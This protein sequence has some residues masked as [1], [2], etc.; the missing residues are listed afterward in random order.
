[1][2]QILGTK[3]TSKCMYCD[4]EAYGYGCPYSPHHRHVHVDDSKRCIYCGSTNFGIGCPYN[5]FAKIHV[6]GLEFNQMLKDS[7]YKSF[8]AGI[9]L[10]RLLEPI[11]ESA[12][13]KL[14]LID[15]N[16]CKVKNPE[17]QEELNAHTPLDAYICKLRRL[18]GEDKMEMLNSGIVVEMLNKRVSQK[19]DSK[20]YEQEMKVKLSVERFV[21]EYK[22]IISESTQQGISRSLIE[23]MIIES[24]LGIN[25]DDD[26]HTNV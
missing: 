20:L 16:G 17:T 14:G 4:A 9:F 19:F 11:I 3:K 1:M 22:N 6:H 10:S 23:E 25:T 2:T 7:A 15:E 8:T 5:P 26:Q 24:I 18:I 13:Y 21:N 12:A